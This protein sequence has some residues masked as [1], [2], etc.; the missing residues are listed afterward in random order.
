MEYLG[1]LGTWLAG[2]WLMIYL[3]QIALKLGR[4]ATALEKIARKP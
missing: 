4:I 2:V 1:G 3:P